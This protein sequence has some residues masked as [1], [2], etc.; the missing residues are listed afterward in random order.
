MSVLLYGSTTWT[1]TK[2]L[3]KKLDGNYVKMLHAVLS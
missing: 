2:S 1:L 3:E